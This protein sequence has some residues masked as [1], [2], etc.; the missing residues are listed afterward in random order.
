MAS[1]SYNELPHI[2]FILL[3][4]EEVIQSKEIRTNKSRQHCF[5]ISALLCVTEVFNSA[6]SSSSRVTCAMTNQCRAA[7]D[8]KCRS[9]AQVPE[10]H[11]S[12]VL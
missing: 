2:D 12:L 1:I 9:L 6:K 7:A 10:L 4:S 3:Q 8:D 5:W 11:C